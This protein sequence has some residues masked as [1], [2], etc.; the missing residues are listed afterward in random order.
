MK[1][2]NFKIMNLEILNGTLLTELIIS[3]VNSYYKRITPNGA[4][5]Q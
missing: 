3:Q 5:F 1:A 2:L 4:M